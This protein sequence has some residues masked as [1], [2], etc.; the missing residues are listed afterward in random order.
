MYKYVSMDVLSITYFNTEAD[1]LSKPGAHD[2]RDNIIALIS[3][4]VTGF[5]NILC[6]KFPLQNLLNVVDALGFFFGQLRTSMSKIMIKSVCNDLII[7]CQ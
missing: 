1:I 3:Y 6:A 5:R 7:F 2:L 4:D